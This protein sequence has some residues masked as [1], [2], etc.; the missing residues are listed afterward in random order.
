M[1]TMTSLRSIGNVKVIKQIV[2]KIHAISGDYYMLCYKP[3]DTANVNVF[4]T[5]TQLFPI[6]WYISP[7]R[8][9]LL[10][11]ITSEEKL[12]FEDDDF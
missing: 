7:G 12:S 3:R 5:L 1:C 2:I 8:T 9:E 10:R 11:A 4:Y 6:L